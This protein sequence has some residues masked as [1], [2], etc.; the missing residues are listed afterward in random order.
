VPEQDREFR[1]PRFRKFHLRNY[2]SIRLIKEVRDD[3]ATRPDTVVFTGS[4][5][6]ENG[7]RLLLDIAEELLRR[8]VSVRIIAT[9]RFC[10]E[11]YRRMFEEQLRTRRLTSI[12]LLPCVRSDRIMDLLNQAT[13]GLLPDLRA[14]KCLQGISTRLFEYMAAGLPV[15]T[16]DVGF[17]GATIAAE[18]TGLLA[19]PESPATFAD[20]IQRLAQDRRL[21]AEMGRRG[22]AAFRSRYTWESQIPALLDYYRQIT[23]GRVVGCPAPPPTDSERSSSA[24]APCEY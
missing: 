16:S 22:Q 23:G 18:Q 14:P 7:S 9:D 5:Y 20:A 19:Q 1:S 17:Q 8:G 4:H 15:V 13:V 24:S 10:T 6:D 21:A 3:Y 12:D 11:D 2:A